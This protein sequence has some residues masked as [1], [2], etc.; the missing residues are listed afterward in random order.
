MLFKANAA[1]SLMEALWV[2]RI[3][4]ILKYYVPAEA[5]KFDPE[6]SA[7]APATETTGISLSKSMLAAI[8][9]QPQNASIYFKCMIILPKDLN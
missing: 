2:R 1:V 7:R 5:T 9:F 8:N 6:Y 4:E 3:V